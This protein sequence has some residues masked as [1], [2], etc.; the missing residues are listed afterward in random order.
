MKATERIKQGAHIEKLRLPQR[1]G[2]NIATRGLLKVAH[3]SP[4]NGCVIEGPVYRLREIKAV[5][6]GQGTPGPF[7]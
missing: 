4:Y 2:Y 5:L 6:W 1:F 3:Q 7:P